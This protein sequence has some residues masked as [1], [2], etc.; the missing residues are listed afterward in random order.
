MQRSLDLPD[1]R[2]SN[3]REIRKADYKVEN[4]NYVSMI[5]E[6]NAN[7]VGAAHA[8]EISRSLPMLRLRSSTSS[9][10][11]MHC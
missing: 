4:G 10:T 1:Q 6:K 2:I 3:A 11:W 7:E 8:A 9:A 5:D